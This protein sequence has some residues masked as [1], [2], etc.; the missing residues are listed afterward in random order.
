M[1]SVA[2]KYSASR[3]GGAFIA[4]KHCCWLLQF[5]WAFRWKSTI[6]AI[7]SIA[8]LIWLLTSLY[9]ALVGGQARQ[10]RRVSASPTSGLGTWRHLA[11]EKRR[12][13]MNKLGLWACLWSNVYTSSPAQKSQSRWRCNTGFAIQALLAYNTVLLLLLFWVLRFHIVRI[14]WCSLVCSETQVP[15]W[16]LLSAWPTQSLFGLVWDSKS[17]C[18]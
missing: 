3:S 15:V 13:K 8:L 16:K 1:R 17:A 10:R 7:V 2:V 6:L 12:R 11:P 18:C 14:Y 4:V 9:A 5:P